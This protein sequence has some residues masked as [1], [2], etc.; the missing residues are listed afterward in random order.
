MFSTYHTTRFADQEILSAEELVSLGHR[1]RK[2]DIEARD[3]LTERHIGSAIVTA[4]KRWGRRNPHLRE[5]ITAAVLLALVDAAGRWDPDRQY[6]FH[7]FAARRFGM[8]VRQAIASGTLP[9]EFP[10]HF[11]DAATRSWHKVNTVRSGPPGQRS[12]ASEAALAVWTSPP[13]TRPVEWDD[14]QVS[15]NPELAEIDNRL[16]CETLLDMLPAEEREV[17]VQSYG[18]DGN[19]PKSVNEIVGVSP[20]RADG[21]RNRKGE[22]VGKMIRRAERRLIEATEEGDD[23]KRRHQERKAADYAKHKAWYRNNRSLAARQLATH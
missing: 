20:T 14:R 15:S 3:E 1:A 6:S 7:V 19:E 4:W 9:F 10:K 8:F 18:L 16:D 2:G 22:R 12:E 23:A 11:T 17:I 5:D 13:A 21:R